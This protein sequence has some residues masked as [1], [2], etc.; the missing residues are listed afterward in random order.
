VRGLGGN[1]GHSLRDSDYSRRFIVATRWPV[2]AQTG[3]QQPLARMSVAPVRTP[4]QALDVSTFKLGK[5]HA[6]HDPRVPMLTK[7]LPVKSLPPPPPRVDWYSEIAEWGV[8]KN[9][10]LS[11]CTCAAVAHVILQ[12]TTYASPDPSEGRRL[13]DEDVVDLYEAV[14]GYN[15]ADESTDQGAVEVDVLNYW[16]NE[17]VYGDRLAGYASLEVG[18]INEIKDAINWFGNVYVGLLLPVTAQ[19][20]TV[21]SVAPGGVNGPGARGSW[22]GHAVPVVGYDERGLICVTWGAL[23]RMTYEFWSAYCDEAYALLSTDF[24]KAAGT[25]TSAS[26]PGGL[27]WE[28]LQA[29]MQALK[30]GY[31]GAKMI[32]HI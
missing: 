19:T 31:V 26:S 5:R 9:D 25:S 28:E 6:R 3:E 11:D 30:A 4:A 17:G 24:I 16:L 1:Q 18:N 29:D 32:R 7:Y 14:G 21:W 23:R 20:Q 10:A 2:K 13:S 27:S 15:P 12:W 8:M 22:G